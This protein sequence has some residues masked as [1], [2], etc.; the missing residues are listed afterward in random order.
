ME[1]SNDQLTR[2]K[3]EIRIQESETALPNP[4]ESTHPEDLPLVL[5]AIE[6]VFSYPSK[7]STAEYRFKTKKG[8]WIWVESTFSNQF[9]VQGLES[10]VVNFKDIS[11][12][13][14][15]EDT[16]LFN[17]FA[18]D[19]MSDCAYWIDSEGKICYVNNASCQMPG[20]DR[21]EFLQMSIS[22]IARHDHFLNW[23]RHW[24]ALKKTENLFFESEAR[25]REIN[26]T[27]DKFFSIIAHD[28]KNPFNAII[29]FSDL[30]VEQVREKDYEGIDLLIN[31]VGIFLWK[32]KLEKGENLPSRSP[33][34][35]KN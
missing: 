24:H 34:K 25:L 30:L 6:R 33:K 8:N 27:K 21:E 26:A 11:G 23:S 2:Q 4:S 22:D 13:K 17:R 35:I 19:Q 14:E 7:V 16:L 12:R 20:Y 28:R 5:S 32:A 3:F 29:G 10:L 15:T 1:T 9:S 31:I 18:S